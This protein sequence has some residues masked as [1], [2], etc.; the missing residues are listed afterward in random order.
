MQ[1]LTCLNLSNNRFSSFTAFDPLRLITSLKILD[2][3]YNEIGAHSVDTTR[4]LCSSP[5]SQTMGSNWNAED[6]APDNVE[7]VNYWE[8]VFIFKDLH[9][10]QLDAVGNIIND[11]NFRKLML[12]TV[13]SLKFLDGAYVR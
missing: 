8:V 6:C 4:Y 11:E 2:I 5:V 10:T 13:P 7:L 3:S 1:L 12:M 9:L